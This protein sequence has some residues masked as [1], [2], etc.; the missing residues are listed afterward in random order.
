MVEKLSNDYKCGKCGYCFDSSRKAKAHEILCDNQKLNKHMPN[1]QNLKIQTPK[2][3][4][5]ESRQLTLNNT[6]IAKCTNCNNKLTSEN[7]FD[8]ENNLIECTTC[9]NIIR[10]DKK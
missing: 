7:Y 3:S 10:A 6:V 8:K 9:D 1:I 4:T 5:K 2:L